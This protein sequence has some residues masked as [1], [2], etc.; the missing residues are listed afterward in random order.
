MIRIMFLAIVFLTI[1]GCGAV[2]FYETEKVSL[3][4]E[5]RPDP[6]APVAG[7]LGLKQRVVLIAPATH[8]DDAT[9]ATTGTAATT[10]T[11][12]LSKRPAGDALSVINSFRFQIHA[13]E[14]G[15]WFPR[16]TIDGAL[17]TG[18]PARELSPGETSSAIGALSGVDVAPIVG[19][20]IGVHRL[21][22]DAVKTAQSKASP[23]TPDRQKLDDLMSRLNALEAIVPDKYNV[24][25]FSGTIT[26][27][28]FDPI[29]AFT[30]GQPV[31]GTGFDR[32]LNYLAALNDSVTALATYR[33]TAA[34]PEANRL[35]A[36]KKYAEVKQIKDALEAALRASPEVALLRDYWRQM[37]G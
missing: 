9:P 16:M 21:M 28:A 32:V 31:L 29:P 3:T 6:T 34:N 26:S 14:Q 1:T 36:G 23:G 27:G 10:S 24:L 5:G 13:K 37:G 33:D 2:Y 7:N 4:L 22:F 35:A 20:Q 19:H 30:P 15:Q 17:I 11:T 25:I 8:T 18:Q 12:S